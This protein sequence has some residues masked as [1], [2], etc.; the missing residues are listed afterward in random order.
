MQSNVFDSIPTIL[1]STV[2]SDILLPTYILANTELTKN[3]IILC[4][5]I[6]IMSCIIMLHA[7]H[8]F[9]NDFASSSDS[10]VYFRRLNHLNNCWRLQ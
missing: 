9:M 7:H 6:T 4:N 10:N 3:N 5:F 1:S 8:R 2:Y